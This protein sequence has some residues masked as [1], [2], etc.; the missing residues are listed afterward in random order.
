MDCGNVKY[1]QLNKVG[2]EPI[3]LG[4][5]T[6]E[7]GTCLVVKMDYECS[8]TTDQGIALVDNDKKLAIDTAMSSCQTIKA[9]WKKQ[10]IEL[11]YPLIGICIEDGY[12][13]TEIEKPE[14]K[15][16]NITTDPQLNKD[17]RIG[18]YKIENKLP[19]IDQLSCCDVLDCSDVLSTTSI[20]LA[21]DELG[22]KGCFLQG[23]IGN[24]KFIILDTSSKIIWSEKNIT[25]QQ[26]TTS[27]INH[28]IKFLKSSQTSNAVSIKLDITLVS[29]IIGYFYI[30]LY[31][32]KFF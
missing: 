13:P 24:D 31:Y 5:C 2:S 1:Y 10:D 22:E 14:I 15:T 7:I 21:T 9:K 12:T 30:L 27:L 4:D 23:T 17:N 28:T 16:A 19:L 25:A 18:K 26:G 8:K 3:K 6:T 29:I 11:H 32:S 20:I